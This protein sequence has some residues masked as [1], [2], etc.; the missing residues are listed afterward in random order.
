MGKKANISRKKEDSG[1]KEYIAYRFYGEPT[2]EQKAQFSRT[3]GCARWLYNQMTATYKDAVKEQ[4]PAVFHSPAWYKDDYPWLREVDSLAL[5]NVQINFQNALSEHR[6]GNRG[7]PSFKKKSDYNDSYT[8]NFVNGNIS[9][10]PGKRNGH[11]HLPKTEGTILIH[12]HRPVRPNGTLKSVTVT[13]EPN[14]R[15][16]F[17]ILFE[18]DLVKPDY[19]INPDR[20]IGLDMSMH[21]FYVDSNGETVDYGKP[22]HNIQDRLARE[23]RKLS[24]MKIGSSNYGKQRRKIASL[25]AKAKHQRKDALHKLSRNLVDKYDI[26]GVEDLNMKGM[27]Q[28]LNFGRSVGDKGWGI[29]TSFLAYKA[30][31]RGKYFVKVDRFFPSSQMCH[32]CGTLYKGVKNL[33]VR[34]W[35]CPSC[36]CHHGRDVNAAINL[37]S[38]AV[39]LYCTA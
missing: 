17:S 33:S 38:E 23:Q 30:A 2:D 36:G 21:H 15:Y 4:V 1:T 5:A 37:R 19:K 11:L 8:T 24:H 31:K 7:A 34:E 28:A 26:I 18:Y 14:G 6:K 10:A 35:T 25:H 9:F 39:R 3:F 27:S 12:C 16:Y 29:F 22:Y 32:E 20:A 13:R